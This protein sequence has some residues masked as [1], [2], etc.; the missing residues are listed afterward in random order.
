MKKLN[1]LYK[2]GDE[3][4]LK[5]TR[6]HSEGRMHLG[7]IT[8]LTSTV[9]V[10]ESDAVQDSYDKRIVCKVASDKVRA[11]EHIIGMQTERIL[12]RRRVTWRVYDV[13]AASGL[14]MSQLVDDMAEADWVGFLYNLRNNMKDKAK[15]AKLYSLFPE[16]KNN[17]ANST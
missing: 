17:Q 6:I 10:V 15:R 4:I 7:R 16:Y 11:E 1:E 3:V 9:I 12:D 13:E 5:D 2:V 8:K 14:I